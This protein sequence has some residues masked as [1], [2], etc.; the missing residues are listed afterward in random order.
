MPVV[1]HSD[2]SVIFAKFK[3]STWAV[4]HD[5]AENNLYSYK[6]FMVILPMHILKNAH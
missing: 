6:L 2:Q 1:E 5:V 4:D 3:G